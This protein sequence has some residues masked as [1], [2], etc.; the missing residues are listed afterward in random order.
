MLNLDVWLFSFLMTSIRNPIQSTEVFFQII[1]FSSSLP[2][3]YRN[4]LNSW[5]SYFHIWSHRSILQVPYIFLLV[6]NYFAFSWIFFPLIFQATH[7]IL[8][9]TILLPWLVWLSV[10]GVLLQTESYQFDAWSGHMPALWARSLDGGVWRQL[11]GVFLSHRCSLPV[12]LPPFPSLK[13]NN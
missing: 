6:L 8:N 3:N 4:S 5:N 1:Y 9:L 7:L 12:F 11:I 13:I 2:S 10:L